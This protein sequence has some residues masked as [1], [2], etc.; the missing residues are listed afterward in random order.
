MLQTRCLHWPISLKEVLLDAQW[1]LALCTSTAE[2][3]ESDFLFLLWILLWNKQNEIIA[4]SNRQSWCMKNLFLQYFYLNFFFI[5]CCW[6]CWWWWCNSGGQSP[7]LMCLVQVL[8]L[9]LTISLDSK[10]FTGIWIQTRLGG[11]S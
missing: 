11:A 1:K 10:M 6:C 3:I 8:T 7:S 5:C 4:A 9:P 2:G